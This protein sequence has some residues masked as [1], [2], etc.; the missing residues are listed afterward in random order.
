MTNKL[1]LIL[2]WFFFMSFTNLPV[3]AQKNNITIKDLKQLYRELPGDAYLPNAFG[4]RKTA[5]GYRFKTPV[6]RL[7]TGSTIFT[8]QVNVNPSGLNI[9]GDAA[10]EPSLAVNPLNHNQVA[11]GWRQF[12]NV[13]SNFRQGGW[14]YTSN[15]GQTWTYG[16]LEP[17][18]FR[19]D[20]VLDYD[21]N[22]NFYY[23]SLTN[24]PTYLCKVFRSYNSGVTWDSGVD[25]AGG[26]KQWMAIDRSGGVGN[27]NIY[28]FWTLGFSSCS[29][30]HFVRS[31]TGGNSY[32]PCLPITGEP[33][34]GTM[35][36]GKNGELYIAGVGNSNDSL[37]IV[38]SV[39][40]QTPGSSVIWNQ[41]VN[42]Y[43]DG[44]LNGFFGV[45]PAGLYGQVNVDV[46]RSNGPNAN[47]VYI[48]ASISRFSNF[49]PADVIFVRSSD[50]GLTWSSPI[51]V[52]DDISTTN[53][54][55][56][57][58]M[59]VAPNGRIDAIWLD[60]RLDLSGLDY[61]AL[62]YSYSTNAGISWSPNEQLSPMFDPHIGYPNQLK[63]GDYFDMESTNSGVHL[64]WTNTLNGEQ[65]V[66]YSFIVPP[67][68]TGIEQIEVD[69][70][71]RIYPVPSDGNVIVDFAGVIKQLD[72]YDV[73]GSLKSST[74][75]NQF[76]TTIDLTSFESGI[77]FVKVTDLTG[78]KIT[79]KII[80]Q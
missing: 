16:V 13:S 75:P 48:M 10:N 19:S 54:Q 39:N 28:S 80:R 12:D 66:Y 65:D 70:K 78:Q 5:P 69:Q 38:K 36:V 64:A 44:Y 1:I 60:T 67:V 61:S 50:G 42:V 26:D 35:A 4:N 32:E 58:T 43:V 18:I 63:M 21:I 30:G 77:Y 40:S 56:F 55:W 11:I 46:D 15:G 62:F 33:A 47:N 79:R 41:S 53:T 2:F 45:N 3:F 6:L 37:S 17:G 25:A 29:P 9:I 73:L 34:L 8:N 76:T 31:A 14:A 52:N 24:S 27:G 23:N 57:A 68:A 7:Q 72:V 20:P 49:D 22:G 74:Y 59:G 71:L 51:V